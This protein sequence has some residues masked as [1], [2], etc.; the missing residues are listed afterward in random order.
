MRKRIS[1]IVLA[2]IMFVS[3]LPLPN[4]NKIVVAEET[5]IDITDEW[6][7]STNNIFKKEVVEYW[8]R[9]LTINTEDTDI[10]NITNYVDR[11]QDLAIKK[12]SYMDWYSILMREDTTGTVLK[13]PITIGTLVTMLDHL[14]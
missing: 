11:L 8:L 10:K 7:D 4:F 1:V 14:L 13:M 2:I 12:S 6:W 9:A 3:V 5:S